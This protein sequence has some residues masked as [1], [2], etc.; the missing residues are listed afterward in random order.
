MVS[1]EMIFTFAS[2]DGFRL[3]FIVFVGK[4]GKN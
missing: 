2:F 1:V 3:V 4:T